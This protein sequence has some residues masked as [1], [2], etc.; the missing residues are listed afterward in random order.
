MERHNV[1][2]LMSIPSINYEVNYKINE[3]INMKAGA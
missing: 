1:T 2:Y 3:L